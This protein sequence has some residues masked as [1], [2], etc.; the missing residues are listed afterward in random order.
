MWRA[1][2]LA[3]GVIMLVLG[4][5]CSMLDHVHLRPSAIEPSS[6]QPASIV[7]PVW[8]P[9]GWARYLL[10]LGGSVVVLCT[11]RV[12]SPGDQPPDSLTEDSLQRETSADSLVALLDEELE[13][14]RRVASD[15][16]GFFD[17]DEEDFFDED[18]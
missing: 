5:E 7:G 4:I 10:L 8:T 3:I 16:S 15:D 9:P 18:E 12:A 13:P 1:F 2:L 6:S 14:T 11:W 17:F